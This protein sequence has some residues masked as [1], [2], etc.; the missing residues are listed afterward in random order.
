MHD[1]REVSLDLWGTLI[2]SN[3]HF[4]Q[5][6]S[7]SLSELCEYSAEIVTSTIA[8]LKDQQNQLVESTGH[9][10]QS[11]DLFSI[12]RDTLGFKEDPTTIEALY[13]ECFFRFL[14]QPIEDGLVVRIEA[15]AQRYPVHLISNTMMVRSESLR[16]VL[17]R[18]GILDYFRSTTFSD[19]SG[20][21]KPHSRIFEI[22]FESTN[23]AANEVVHFGDNPVTDVAGASDFGFQACLFDPRN[24]HTGNRVGSLLEFCQQLGV[25]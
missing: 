11:Q 21:S 10:P 4:K 8:A 3:P 20:F 1:V 6:V 15:L 9:S 13:S 12:L 14:P 25:A 24:V 18:L 23:C 5:E 2:A 22:A 19:E 16:E 7:K 17:R